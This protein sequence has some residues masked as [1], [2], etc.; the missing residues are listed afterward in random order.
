MGSGD[1]KEESHRGRA[2]SVDG[3][4]VLILDEISKTNDTVSMLYKS[5]FE[6][7]HTWRVDFK[8]MPAVTAAL[9]DG[10]DEIRYL[11][12]EMKDKHGVLDMKKIASA[13]GAVWKY[14]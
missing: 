8:F 3:A 6:V 11:K 7:I 9:T 12:P 13:T 5:T 10:A 4:A 1:V 2:S 14:S